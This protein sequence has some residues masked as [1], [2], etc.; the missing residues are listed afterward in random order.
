[1]TIRPLTF[2]L[3]NYLAMYIGWQVFQ[4]QLPTLWA[5]F[6]V[7]VVIAAIWVGHYH[8]TRPRKVR[9]SRQEVS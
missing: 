1:M 3:V 9:R 5:H 8:G 7:W 2:S 6:C 4:H